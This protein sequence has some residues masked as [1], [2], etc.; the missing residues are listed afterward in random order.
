MEEKNIIKLLH[1]IFDSEIKKDPDLNPKNYQKL[2]E[3][4]KS[5]DIC[6][7]IDSNGKIS[8]IVMPKE[9]LEYYNKKDFQNCLGI[10][11]SKLVRDIYIHNSN[12]SVRKRLK[13]YKLSFASLSEQLSESEL[14]YKD[15]R[16][17]NL[18][19]DD[20]KIAGLNIPKDQISAYIK[21]SRDEAVKVRKNIEDQVNS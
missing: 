11:I 2:M 13:I 14:G 4:H 6:A 20:L 19:Y 12:A 10:C 17:L 21:K 16:V 7:K 1:G 5:P 9:A 8:D 15:W 3:K 18:I